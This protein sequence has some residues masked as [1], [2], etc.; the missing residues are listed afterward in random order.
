VE[1][2]LNAFDNITGTIVGIVWHDNICWVLL[3]IGLLFTVLTRG[4]QFRCIPQM[5]KL[6]FGSNS[7]NS[8]SQKGIS[9]LQALMI[10][11]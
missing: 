9:N 8:D 4:V 1:A 3:V 10:A 7:K 5:F 2:F 11:V 6:L